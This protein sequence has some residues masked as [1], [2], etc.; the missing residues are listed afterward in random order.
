MPSM[1]P[2]PDSDT[3]SLRTAPL[4]GAGTACYSERSTPT[5]GERR[6]SPD[7]QFSAGSRCRP[8]TRCGRDDLAN[9][10]GDRTLLWI[11][12]LAT[13][14][15][16][17]LAAPFVLRAWWRSRSV[18]EAPEHEAGRL[19]D[20]GSIFR[21]VRDGY[22]PHPVGLTPARTDYSLSPEVAPNE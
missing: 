15:L 20:F 10:L 4:S 2:Q 17:I 12:T 11:I 22:S 9:V 7:R 13:S 8:S 5:A 1:Q 19:D 14:L 18:R 3:R 6:R 21:L 16:W